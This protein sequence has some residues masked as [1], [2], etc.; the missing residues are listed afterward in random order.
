MYGI[1]TETYTVGLMTMVSCAGTT[2]SMSLKRTPCV[3][4]TTY[5]LLATLGMESRSTMLSK[6]LPN[7]QYKVM[8]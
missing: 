3:K 4:A 7:S 8:S 6:S 2:E 1:S 5:S